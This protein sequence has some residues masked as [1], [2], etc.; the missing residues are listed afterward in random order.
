MPKNTEYRGSFS[1]EDDDD[2]SDCSID[3]I[4]AKP[5]LA[6]FKPTLSASL[7]LE[8]VVKNYGIEERDRKLGNDDQHDACRKH[9]RSA[10]NE[11][12]SSVRMLSIHLSRYLHMNITQ[13]T[14]QK[15]LARHALC[16]YRE[17][18]KMD[19]LADEYFN[20]FLT[21][22]QGHHAIRKQLEQSTFEPLNPP[23]ELNTVW[24]TPMFV[25]LEMNRWA[26]AI[27]ATTGRLLVYG[28]AWSLTTLK[29]QAWDEYNIVNFF[30]PE[31][32]HL[33]KM[34]AYRRVDLRG[35]QE[36]IKLDDE[37]A[38]LYD[39]NVAPKQDIG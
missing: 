27:G 13:P 6:L 9:I 18:L 31:I 16:W 33:E 3:A 28:V 32:H 5:H 12:E 39:N 36:K 34:I 29:H 14:L 35:F 4:I 23:E 17:T 38:N 8:D 20:V 10:I 2:T 24:H 37:F 1:F 21:S 19:S 11:L 30:A 26:E 15:C 7:C 25:A 22:K